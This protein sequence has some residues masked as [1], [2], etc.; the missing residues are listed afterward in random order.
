MSK[1]TD[2]IKNNKNDIFKPIIVLLSIC[3]II[4]LALSLT[5]ELT[6]DR[7]KTLQEEKEKETMSS[8]IDADSFKTYT[9]EGKDETFDFNTA[10]KDDEVKGYI[11]VT[12]AKG[13]GGEISVMTALDVNGKVIEVSILDAAN[14]TPGLGQN[15]TKESFY[16]Q[17][18][19][20]TKGIEVVKGGVTTKDNEINAVTGASISSKAV[21]DAVDKAISQFEEYSGSTSNDTEVDSSEKQ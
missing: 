13:Y 18:K 4:P 21:R 20:K 9:F 7:I 14:E 8:L 12:S 17:F 6:A 16:S 15:V 19:G 1:F 10:I 5:N 11:F 3:I 2:F